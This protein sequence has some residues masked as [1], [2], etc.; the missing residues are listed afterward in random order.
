[1]NGRRESGRS[2]RTRTYQ[3]GDRQKKKHRLN[4]VDA[5]TQHQRKGESEKW[6]QWPNFRLLSVIALARPT[7]SMVAICIM[8]ELESSAPHV[9][10]QMRNDPPTWGSGSKEY[11]NIFHSYS[12][13]E[14]NTWCDWKDCLS[15]VL[16]SFL[17]ATWTK[18]LRTC[19]VNQNSLG[20]G[21]M[22]SLD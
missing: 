10:S 4:R 15:R 18:K 16:V 8:A 17:L 5:H 9:L 22:V 3:L 13:E 7:P 6:R 11:T 19:A 2:A 21:Q 14:V 20:W 1:M 12:Q